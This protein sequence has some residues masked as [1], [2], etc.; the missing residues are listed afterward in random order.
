MVKISKYGRDFDLNQKIFFSGREIICLHYP[1][2]MKNPSK[3]FLLYTFPGCFPHENFTLI[4][5]Y[6]L[7][8]EAFPY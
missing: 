6:N 2:N 8:S 5:S 1:R 7:Q 3:N 4:S